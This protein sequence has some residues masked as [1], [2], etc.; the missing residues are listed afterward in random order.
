LL[1]SNRSKLFL[2]IVGGLLLFLLLYKNSRREQHVPIKIE[3][4]PQTETP[5]TGGLYDYLSPGLATLRSS[6]HK[7]VTVAAWYNAR[8]EL[9]D[10]WYRDDRDH[11]QVMIDHGDVLVLQKGTEVTILE[12]EEQYSHVRIRTGTYRGRTAYA[13]NA[14]MDQKK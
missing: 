10:A 3:S 12:V 13:W 2:V 11:I 1:T 9:R 8:D 5:R 14:D 4:V 6:S 7:Q